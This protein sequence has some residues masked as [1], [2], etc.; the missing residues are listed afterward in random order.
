[1]KRRLLWIAAAG[2]LLVSA[3]VAAYPALRVRQ[4]AGQLRGDEHEAGVPRQALVTMLGG[5]AVPFFTARL[6][7]PEPNVRLQSA[8]A[9][10]EL[11]GER[12]LPVLAPHMADYNAR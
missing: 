6:E 8:E 2:T 5:R 3:A 12:S 1:M 4:L 10:F 11:L 7:D 9:L